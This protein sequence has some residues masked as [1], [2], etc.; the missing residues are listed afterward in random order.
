ML[1]FVDL[2]AVLNKNCR[3]RYMGKGRRANAVNSR[4]TNNIVAGQ[5]TSPATL[6]LYMINYLK[7]YH[8]GENRRKGVDFIACL[9]E[10]ED[11]RYIS[12]PT[13]DP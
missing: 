2:F 8:L 6:N 7:K 9:Q 4:K 12:R 5:G 13:I 1:T 3:K 10:N 11:S